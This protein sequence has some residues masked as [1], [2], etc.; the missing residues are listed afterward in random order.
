[1]YLCDNGQKAGFCPGE[2]LCLALF[3]GEEEIAAALKDRGISISDNKKRMLTEGHGCTV[4]YIY[5]DCIRT[6][7]DERFLQVMS[8]VVHDVGEDKKL[9]FTNGM[10]IGRAHV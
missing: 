6:M 7:N 3:A 5:I 9:H 4:W 10:E 1:M 2:L 8:E